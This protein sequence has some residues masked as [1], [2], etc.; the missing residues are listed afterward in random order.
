MST[1]AVSYVTRFL[2]AF[3][4]PVALTTAVATDV[5]AGVTDLAGSLMW[6][7]TRMYDLI[8]GAEQR[9]IGRSGNQLEIT[10]HGLVSN[11]PVQ[12]FATSGGTL[13]PPLSATIVY[14]VRDVDA[15]HIELSATSGPGAAIA[16]I[17]DGSAD[18]WAQTV[19]AWI[20]SV[21][22]S[23]ATYGTGKL[24]DLVMWLAGAQTVS[25]AK[26]FAGQVTIGGTNRLGYASRGR[27]RR[28]K[29]ITN[30][31]DSG[32]ELMG[33]DMAVDSTRD[34]IIELPNGSTVTSLTIYIDP[35]THASLPG[36]MPT[37][38]LKRLDTA[39]SETN[40]SDLATDSSANAGAYSAAHTIVVNQQ[41]GAPLS[42]VIDNSLY[43]YRLTITGESGANKDIFALSAVTSLF[44]V[45]EQDDGAS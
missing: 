37:A 18:Q 26:T 41:S 8:F 9:I 20:S 21:L 31:S 6:L 43:T 28:A 35:E 17:A 19:P 2:T 3:R 24:R 11:T 13:P 5:R 29:F 33:I 36:T 23:D 16:L 45:T 40:V 44:S 10:G 14:Y 32:A 38:R 4:G 27:T 42:L 30:G 39:G 1:S 12:V 7:K 22:V 34:V 15:D 25:G